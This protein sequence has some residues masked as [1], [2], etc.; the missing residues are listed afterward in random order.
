MGH[1]RLLQVQYP[2]FVRY[3]QVVVLLLLMFDDGCD[4]S[5]WR[6]LNAILLAVCFI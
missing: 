1:W 6:L 4:K 5:S 2:L 3:W